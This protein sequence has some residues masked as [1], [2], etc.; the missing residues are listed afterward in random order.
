MEGTWEGEDTGTVTSS[1]D[2]SICMRERV[3]CPSLLG[4]QNI[5]LRLKSHL[6]DALLPLEKSQECQ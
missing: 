4:K 1:I 3:F 6:E 2:S 5:A